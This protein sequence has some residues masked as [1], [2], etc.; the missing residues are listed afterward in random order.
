MTPNQ[1]KYYWREWAACRR[2]LIALGNSA[3]EADALRH[4]LHYKALGKA[5]SSKN[6]TNADLDKI[7][8]TFKSYSRPSDLDTQ[9]DAINQPRKRLIWSISKLGLT[10]A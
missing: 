3:K 9:L 7:L 5:Q 1:R 10:D 6:L 8:A 4:D 2:S